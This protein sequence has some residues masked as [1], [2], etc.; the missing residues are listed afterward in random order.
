MAAS[1]LEQ[2]EAHFLSSCLHLRMLPWAEADKEWLRRITET[3]KPALKEIQHLP[4]LARFLDSHL[5]LNYRDGEDW[6]DVHPLLWRE[7]RSGDE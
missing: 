4:Q 1:T 5:V 7:L 6:Y 3:K 2:C